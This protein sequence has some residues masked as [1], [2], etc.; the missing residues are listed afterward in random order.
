MLSVAAA[1]T[2][3]LDR[4][5]SLRLGWLQVVLENID[6]SVSF[7]TDSFSLITLRANIFLAGP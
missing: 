5:L 1:V 4:N 6:R 7:Y 3:S 2:I